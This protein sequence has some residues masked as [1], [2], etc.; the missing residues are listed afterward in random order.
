M[1]QD[2]KVT[3]K[4]VGKLTG[5][6]W[7]KMHDISRRVYSV[8]YVA[9]TLHTMGGGNTEV[10]ILVK[11]S[12]KQ[13]F[14]TADVGDSIN[15]AFPTSKTRRGRVGHG[16]AHTIL[17]GDPQQGVIVENGKRLAPI[18]CAI[19]GRNPDNPSDRSAGIP[20]AQRIELGGDVANCI[21]TVQKD[22][23]VAI[24]QKSKLQLR[25][26]Q[27]GQLRCKMLRCCRKGEN[28]KKLRYRIRKLTERECFR[29]M[30]VKSRDFERVAQNQSMSSLY[31][32]AGDSI[33]TAC[34]MAVFGEMIP[35]T[36][37]REKIIALAQE[38]SENSAQKEVAQ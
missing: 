29:L 28:A 35:N 14:T 1:V 36:R 7:D 9:P 22:S 18:T 8:D 27:G 26:R 12:N 21:T 30:G 23:M 4:E 34:L 13:G 15:F 31:H 24:P 6:K 38:V 5:G 25:K 37:Y 2:K 19:R 16:V 32:L 33:V 20:L 3:C 17:T 11:E 10:K